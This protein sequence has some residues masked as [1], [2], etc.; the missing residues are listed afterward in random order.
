M[1]PTRDVYLNTSSSGNVESSYLSSTSSPAYYHSHP[2]FTP[3][4]PDTYHTVVGWDPYQ[5]STYQSRPQMAA[6]H[7]PTRSPTLYPVTQSSHTSSAPMRLPPYKFTTSAE[8]QPSIASNTFTHPTTGML[9]DEQQ[10]I[11]AAD[12]KMDED[13]VKL[14]DFQSSLRTVAPEGNQ[15][16]NARLIQWYNRTIEW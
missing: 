15:I 6:I 16:I 4:Q 12:H 3:L 11:T 13:E 10:I 1:D 14:E 9:G 2:S 8:L 5:C 7:S